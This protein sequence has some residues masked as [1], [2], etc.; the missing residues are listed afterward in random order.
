MES[1]NIALKLPDHIENLPIS[2]RIPNQLCQFHC[3]NPWKDVYIRYNGGLI[4]IV[5]SIRHSHRK[6]I[7]NANELQKLRFTEE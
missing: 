3:N 1:Y 6:S 4:K 7:D 2:K 5:I